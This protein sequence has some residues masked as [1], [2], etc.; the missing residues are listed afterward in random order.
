[1]FGSVILSQIMPWCW[2]SLI[3][4]TLL[5]LGHK[6][7]MDSFRSDLANCSFVKC[8]GN[9]ASVLYEQYTKDLNDL[10]DKHAP[11]VSY[12]FIKG[13]A[14]WLSDSY[15]LAKAVRHQFECIWHKDKS[16]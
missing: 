13:P 4:P 6:I 11:E 8:P 5:H 10:L 2:V 15:L 1:M 9:T 16:P 7:K 14:K 12:T 3:L